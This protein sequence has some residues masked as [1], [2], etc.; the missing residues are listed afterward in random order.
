MTLNSQSF[1]LR[2]PLPTTTMLTD[3]TL[4]KKNLKNSHC[5][6]RS[7]AAISPAKQ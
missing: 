7:D 3:R 5:E 1:L 4:E 2:F 6:E